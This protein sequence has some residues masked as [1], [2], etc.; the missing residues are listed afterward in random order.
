M[1]GTRAIFWLYLVLI[2]AGISYAIVVGLIGR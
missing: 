2:V 1:G